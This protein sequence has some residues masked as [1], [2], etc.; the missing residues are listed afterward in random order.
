MASILTMF[1]GQG[2]QYVGM[3][4]ELC[5]KF[6]VARKTFSEA[7][8]VLGFRLSDLCFT[9][10]EQD[11]RL[12]ANQQ[13]AILTTSIA[14]WRVLRSEADLRPTLFAGHSLGEYSA[15]VATGKLEFSSAVNLVRMRGQAMQKAVPEGTGAMA[16]VIG[17]D[18][19]SLIE[20]CEAV[21]VNLGKVEV[22]NFNSPQQQI[23]SGHKEA[24]E[25]LAEALAGQKIRCSTLPVSA[26]FHSSLM[27]PARDDMTPKLEETPLDSTEHRVIANLTGKLA[28]PYAVDN[29]IRQID[30]PVHWTD[31]LTTA[32]DEGCDSFFEI[33][34]G[35]VLFGLAR[36]TIPR[37]L[38]IIHSDAI[39]KAI[40]SARELQD[41]QC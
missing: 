5:D 1:P 12:T 19:H 14:T 26:P 16:A 37:G 13:P 3:G 6:D 35:K 15:L 41:E 21:D 11:L 4:K 30:S 8:E 27:A 20:K 40:A 17:M 18:P 29:L 25:A 24:V 23:V 33:G 38:K 34:P 31:T 39:E 28:H 10:P 2:S 7:D 9:G 22:V 36:K 32:V